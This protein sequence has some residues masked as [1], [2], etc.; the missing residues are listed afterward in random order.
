M[1]TPG[2]LTALRQV[3]RPAGRVPTGPLCPAAVAYFGGSARAR[4]RIADAVRRATTAGPC[5]PP[6]MPQRNVL[7]TAGTAFV[8]CCADDLWAILPVGYTPGE[9]GAAEKW[10]RALG[11][12]SAPVCTTIAPAGEQRPTEPEPLAQLRNEFGPRPVRQRVWQHGGFMRRPVPRPLPERCGGSCG[13]G[14]AV[15]FSCQTGPSE[16]YLTEC[17]RPSTPQAFAETAWC[18][19]Y[20]QSHGAIGTQQCI[21]A[22]IGIKPGFGPVA[23]PPAPG[24]ICKDGRDMA[25][26]VTQSS[27][28]PPGTEAFAA[29]GSIKYVN[30]VISF[31]GGTLQDHAA[32][33]KAFLDAACGPDA[34]FTLWFTWAGQ[35]VDARKIAGRASLNCGAAVTIRE[36]AN[37]TVA[38]AAAW[39]Y[40]NCAPAQAGTW[41][42]YSKDQRRQLYV[43]ALAAAK[44]PAGSRTRRVV[45]PAGVTPAPLYVASG[46]TTTGPTAP[47]PVTATTSCG[48][49]ARF[50][51]IFWD[52]L[53]TGAELAA[54]G[55]VN[56][57]QD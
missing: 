30:H 23:H 38:E 17:R 37:F 41:S 7:Q 28:G 39:F 40:A 29:A 34:P 44:P 6:T 5:C 45:A 53:P 16:A 31:P 49:G 1:P 22:A 14:P 26:C 57:R 10:L 4:G 11:A 25:S 35:R 15:V 18:A 13:Q 55:Q 51:Q 33:A 42:D 52:H 48:V 2:V 19:A 50:R 27:G 54:W 21:N 12:T 43:D 32:E 56:C 8:V 9:R 36:G 3:G 47:R 20:A 24:A 46:P